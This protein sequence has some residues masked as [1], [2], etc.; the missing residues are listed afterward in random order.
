MPFLR[1]M[2]ASA[3]WDGEMSSS[4]VGGMRVLV[5]RAGG[6]LRAFED[7]CAHRGMPLS[8]GLLEDCRLTCPHHGWEFDVRAGVSTSPEGARLR[9]LPLKVEEGEIWVEVPEPMPR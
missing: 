9:S 4:T 2:R 3:L 5:I 7:R 8:G 1:V 6:E